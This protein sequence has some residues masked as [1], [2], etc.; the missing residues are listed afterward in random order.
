MPAPA[1]RSVQRQKVTTFSISIFVHLSLLLILSGV[2]LVPAFVSQPEFL[3]MS[4][5]VETQQE[6]PP[7][8]LLP[9]D[10]D[11]GGDPVGETV[12]PTTSPDTVDDIPLHSPDLIQTTSPLAAHT[13][14][15]TGSVLAG[16][17]VQMGGGRG[18]SGGGT[19]SGHGTGAGSGRQGYTLFGSS[20]QIEGGL[21]GTF[22]WGPS[23]TQLL[24]AVKAYSSR[25]QTRAFKDFE[26]VRQKLYATQL[27]VPV[28]GA[29]EAPEAF[30]QKASNRT[31]VIHYNGKF[32]PPQSGRYRFIGHADNILHVH[33]DKNLVLDGSLGDWR[34]SPG[35]GGCRVSGW[36]PDLETAGKINSVLE[37][38]YVGDWITLDR[39]THHE[40]DILFGSDGGSTSFGFLAVEKEGDGVLEKQ[41]P[42]HI[43][44]TSPEGVVIPEQVGKNFPRLAPPP[45]FMGP[46]K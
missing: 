32:S 9:D 38:A 33:V 19:G 41:A 42:I 39:A 43:F 44:N 45:Y 37:P 26:A 46:R 16:P 31:W 34:N 3:A 18:G 7:D 35:K 6:P 22:Y 12:G 25:A 14:I 1:D 30:G 8:T 28:V 15:A 5:P 24:T 4:V 13:V 21:T 20:E 29:R 11:G 17:T 23:K 10:P 27:V 40:I 2:V 36:N